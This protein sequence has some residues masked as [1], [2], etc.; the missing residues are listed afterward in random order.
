MTTTPS[1]GS[2][3]VYQPLVMKLRR[4]IDDGHMKP[5][6]MVGSEHELARETGLSRHSVRRAIEVLIGD[7]LIE[8]VPGKGIFVRKPGAATKTVQLVIGSLQWETMMLL[9]RGAQEAGRRR[10]IHLQLYD[11]H[12]D[13]ELDL[14]FIRKLPDTRADGAIIG[15][16]HNR[17][18]AEVLFELKTRGY[19]FVL[20]DELPDYLDVPAVGTDNYEA[21]LTIGRE[22]VK[23]GHRRVGF[24]GDLV[25]PTTR[26]RLDGLRDA[27]SDGGLVFD[28]SLAVDLGEDENRLGDWSQGVRRHARLLLERDD[29]PTA[30]FCSCDAVAAQVYPVCRELGLRIPGDVS[31]VGFDGCA[32]CE[33]LDPPLAT[34]RQPMAEMGEAALEMLLGQLQRSGGGNAERRVIPSQ[35]LP[36]A[37]LGPGPETAPTDH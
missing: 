5:G 26:A 34:M 10:G 21:G 14:E 22:I 19:P 17:R 24:L 28:R 32:M 33:V 12:G 8:R 20:V 11:A 9:A 18:F 36:R 3:T 37:S 15:S 25:A 16:L 29:R 31:L 6:A 2:D 7:G 23:L 1:T 4:S 30:L 13:F 35:W 27:I